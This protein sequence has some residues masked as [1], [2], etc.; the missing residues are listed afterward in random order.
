MQ[1]LTPA[2]AGLLPAKLAAATTGLVQPTPAQLELIDQ[3]LTKMSEASRRS[4]KT[5]ALGTLPN[6]GVTT[7][8][9]CKVKLGQAEASAM[10]INADMN[11][12]AV[13]ACIGSSQ[14]LRFINTCVHEAAHNFTELVAT[15]AVSSS[16]D[17][18]VEAQ[19]IAQEKIQSYGLST[20]LHTLF[21]SLHASAVAEADLTMATAYLSDGGAAPASD[22][23]AARAGFA[24][25]YGA[26]NPWEDIAEY[27]SDIQAP[28]TAPGTQP[29]ICNLFA[30][31]GV[32][33]ELTAIQYA[34]ALL[35]RNIGLIDAE[36]FTGCMHGFG[37]DA[38]PGISAP[39][40]DFQFTG[41]LDFGYFDLAGERMFG[42]AGAGADTYQ[43][44]LRVQVTDGKP[45]LGLHRLDHIGYFDVE[46]AENGFLLA[47]DDPFLARTSTGGL[48][49]I[50][51]ITPHTTSGAIFFLELGD[52]GI[53][54]FSSQAFPVV[55]FRASK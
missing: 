35:L 42:V 22:A 29:A 17:W 47:N 26:T 4:V 44:L 25:A 13:T 49:L 34:K 16:L 27:A 52:L 38:R 1:V 28:R 48:A 55:T 39:N 5:I 18:P 41:D 14:S 36:P 9:G 45:P 19:E 40:S 12:P 50:T 43:A 51:E 21:A 11:D 24:T 6:H 33:S 20:G 7:T 15:A 10:L 37:I 46:D 2:D 23:L 32:L 30:Q 54:I 31:A 53:G 3:C 8:G